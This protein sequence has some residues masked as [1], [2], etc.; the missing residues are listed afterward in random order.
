MTFSKILVLGAGAVG[1]I[2]GAL[3]SKKN[4]VILIGS[5]AHVDAVN[6]KGLSVTGDVNEAF[7]VKAE[8]Q[9]HEIPP[10]ALIFVTTKAYNAEAAAEKLVGLLRNDTVVLVLQNGLGNESLVKRI[11]GNRANVL[12][13]ITSLAS[14]FFQ[15]GEIQYWKGETVIEIG[16]GAEEIAET[17]NICGLRTSLSEDISEQ[18]WSKAVVNCVI[19]PLTGI[20]R[21]RNHEIITA[22]L[23]PIR[24]QVTEEC[25]LV[26]RA[27]G[28]SLP[29]SL[30]T[31]MEKETLRYKNY[32]SMCQDIMK[33]KKTEIGFLNGKIVELGAKNS[34]PTPVNETLFH[35]IKFMEEKKWH[36][37]N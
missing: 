15:P 10:R 8:T 35:L 4:D 30:E 1:S 24:H 5:K 22:S 31:I 3:L 6:S 36:F 18:V 28:I 19:N 7:H 33:G 26:A 37:K 29:G 12:R 25:K 20:F 32:S 23:A 16:T 21:L 14:E 34:I 9:I 11:I 27:E 17:M 2:V 13:G